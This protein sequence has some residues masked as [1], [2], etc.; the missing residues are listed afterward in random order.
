MKKVVIAVLVSLGVVG[1]SSMEH[2]NG[3]NSVLVQNA[4][5]EPNPLQADIKVG[6]QISGTA[7]CESWFGFL[8]KKP[9]RQTYGAVLQVADGNVAPSACAR[10]AIYDALNKSGA[11]MIL[12]PQY[13]SVRKSEGCIFG[14]CIHH[15]DKII[16]TG[17][18]GTLGNIVPM[19]E[20]VVLERKKHAM[21]VQQN[22]SR[23]SKF[24]FWG[25]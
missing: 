4:V 18:K 23:R 6:A 16:V 10:G 24:L 14:W 11:D 9:Q 1:C 8:T 20:E 21:N 15:E 5:I 2:H 19:E 3:R 22:S 13:T 7:S 12:V 17:Y 25:K